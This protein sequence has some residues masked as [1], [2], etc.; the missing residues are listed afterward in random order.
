MA[1]PALLPLALVAKRQ[2]QSAAWYEQA[3]LDREAGRHR[4]ASDAQTIAADYAKEARHLLFG[5]VV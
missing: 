5:E 4:L 3:M 2:A 1:R